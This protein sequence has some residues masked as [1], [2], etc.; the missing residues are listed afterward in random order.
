MFLPVFPYDCFVL[1]DEITG[2]AEPDGI[3]VQDYRIVDV[4]RAEEPILDDDR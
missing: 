2:R 4:E 1:D 3:D